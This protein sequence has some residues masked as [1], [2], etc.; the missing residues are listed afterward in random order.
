M[1]LYVEDMWGA[2]SCV[3][4]MMDNFDFDQVR[5]YCPRANEAYPII[6]P[7]YTNETNEKYQLYHSIKSSSHRKNTIIV[8]EFRALVLG[9]IVMVIARSNLVSYMSSSC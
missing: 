6:Q 3:V 4:A 5:Y 8:Q 7:L 9:G 1:L 2:L